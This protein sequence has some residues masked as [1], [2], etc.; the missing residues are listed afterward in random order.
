MGEKKAMSTMRPR[1]QAQAQALIVSVLLCGTILML[2]GRASGN[3]TSNPQETKASPSLSKVEVQEWIA[4]YCEA[5]DPKNED[6]AEL[7]QT[8][9]WKKFRE[10]VAS[11]PK[12][13][14]GWIIETIPQWKDGQDQDTPVL[15]AQTIGRLAGPQDVSLLAETWRENKGN[16]QEWASF[17]L[18]LCTSPE[19]EEALQR[20]AE[21]S[22]PKEA[23]LAFSAQAALK[24]LKGPNA[25]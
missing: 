17:A 25:P 13:T 23:K 16:S 5:N 3:P 19:N 8:F 10:M 4:R 12:G 2:P 18:A 6:D 21:S 7:V 9:P 24:A 11:L 20:I 22:D 15:M 1:I 14:A